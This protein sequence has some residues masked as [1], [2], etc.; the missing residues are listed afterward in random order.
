MI[1][2]WA[3]G[4]VPST[5]PPVGDPTSVREAEPQTRGPCDMSPLCTGPCGVSWTFCALPRLTAVTPFRGLLSSHVVQDG[6]L[7]QALTPRKVSHFRREEE[8]PFATMSSL[9]RP[10]ERVVPSMDTISSLP[11]RPLPPS[12]AAPPTSQHTY[13]SLR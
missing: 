8:P 3:L 10:L 9:I 4:A 11:L 5:E 2:Q 12:V 7:N 6:I 1:R 13:M